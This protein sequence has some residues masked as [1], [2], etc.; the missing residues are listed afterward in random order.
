MHEV[1]LEIKKDENHSHHHWKSCCMTFDR[2]AVMFFSQ[3]GISIAV[4]VYCGYKLQGLDRFDDS[5][6]WVGFVTFILGV[7]VKTP[8]L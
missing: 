3:L 1:A 7:W 2:H 5:N 4:L 8:S 6:T